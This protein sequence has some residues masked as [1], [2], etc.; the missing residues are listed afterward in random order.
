MTSDYAIQEEQRRDLRLQIQGMER[1]DFSEF[2]FTEWSPGRKMVTLWSMQ[3]GISI[4]IPQYMVGSALSKRW[5]NGFLFTA[6]K[7]KAPEFK[8]GTVRC[9][10]AEGSVERDSGVLA[11]AGLDH[12]PY[13]P[14]HG[15]RSEY[16]K[17]QHGKNRH[18]NSWASLQDFLAR[19]ER[20]ESRDE[21]R[22]ATAAMMQLAGG[23]VAK[24]PVDEEKRQRQRDNM[25]K[26]RAVKQAKAQEA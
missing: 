23:V 12:L 7:T 16:S 3:D 26:A 11:A 22:K 8:D 24:A 25:A 19:Q 5:R 20:E 4:T 2:S 9:F 6:D 13:C 21:Q 1:S 17:T 10:L 15:L 18:T 14:A